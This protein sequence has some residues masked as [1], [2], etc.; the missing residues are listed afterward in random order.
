MNNE[1]KNMIK[2]NES[3][4][5]DY[6]KNETEDKSNCIGKISQATF[7]NTSKHKYNS[8]SKEMKPKYVIT[9]GKCK[10]YYKCVNPFKNFEGG[11]LN[12]IET[13]E[14]IYDETSNDYNDFY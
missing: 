13:N 11:K 9:S 12:I 5:Y 14:T 2:S 10:S 1:T 7:K 4:I 6:M 8:I 3:K